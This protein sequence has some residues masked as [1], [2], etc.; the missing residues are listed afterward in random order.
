MR[1]PI[2]DAQLTDEEIQTAFYSVPSSLLIKGELTRA[3]FHK[4]CRAVA[5]AATAKAQRVAVQLVEELAQA[6]LTLPGVLLILQ[7]ELN[8]AG[9]E[10][11]K[12]EYDHSRWDA[13]KQPGSLSWRFWVD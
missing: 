7:G 11:P 5:D 2:D 12:E 10:R 13:Y 8:I 6:G 9:I 1:L 4:A 3:E